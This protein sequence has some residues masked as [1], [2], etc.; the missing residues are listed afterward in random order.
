[1]QIEQLEF[2]N[3]GLYKWLPCE[4]DICLVLN[5][6]YVTEVDEK[7]IIHLANSQVKK[8]R[9][10]IRSSFPLY[11]SIYKD[12]EFLY[13]ALKVTNVEFENPQAPI[14]KVVITVQELTEDEN[15]EI[16]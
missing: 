9:K 7:L 6:I 2:F 13:L 4:P 14:T 11:L 15:K 16:G 12:K 10:G 8:L 1:M 3:M 5:D